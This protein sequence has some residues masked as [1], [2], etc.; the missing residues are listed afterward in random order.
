MGYRWSDSTA[1]GLGTIIQ[2]YEWEPSRADASRQALLIYNEDDCAALEVVSHKLLDL[3]LHSSEP[4]LRLH[5]EAVDTGTLKRE[6]PY[7]FKSRQ[8]A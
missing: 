1:S 3:Q 4:Q 6:H 8:S 2:R 5:N 7:G